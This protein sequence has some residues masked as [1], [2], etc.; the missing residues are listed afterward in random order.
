MRAAARA[1]RCRRRRCRGRSGGAHLRRDGRARPRTAPRRTSPGAP[2]HWPCRPPTRAAVR[3]TVPTLLPAL[4]TGRAPAPVLAAGAVPRA[5][6]LL[7]EPDDPGDASDALLGPE[8]PVSHEALVGHRAPQDVEPRCR[9]LAVNVLPVG[10]PRGE[11]GEER[12]ALAL[13]GGGDSGVTWCP[14]AERERRR[15]REDARGDVT[16]VGEPEPL[17]VDARLLL[18]PVQHRVAQLAFVGE[19]AVDGPLRGPGP[20]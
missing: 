7:D 17:E 14:G 8:P 13:V 6:G 15:I 5:D 4:V 3:T 2:R 10:R 16:D 1:V 12:L 20:R 9:D 18:E 11:G 19:V